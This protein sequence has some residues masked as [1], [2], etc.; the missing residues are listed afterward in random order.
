MR[1]GKRIGHPLIAR[2]SS[3][4]PEAAFHQVVHRERLLSDRCHRRFSVAIFRLTAHGLRPAIDA[5][6]MGIVAR[7]A[8]ITDDVGLLHGSAVGVLLRETGPD[9]A[10]VFSRR[11]AGDMAKIG[12]DVAWRVFHYPYTEEPD[13]ATPGAPSLVGPR[14]CIPCEYEHCQ[15]RH[16]DRRLSG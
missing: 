15:A 16:L 3:V 11:V 1:R 8:R 4:L 13:S 14:L 10:E 6:S 9:V 2:D 12:A 7:H 5:R